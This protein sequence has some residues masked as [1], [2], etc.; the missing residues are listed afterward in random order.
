M[1]ELLFILLHI[2]VTNIILSNNVYDIS[3]VC[4]LLRSLKFGII[5]I[6]SFS[7]FFLLFIFYLICSCFVVVV[8]FGLVCLFL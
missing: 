2:S 1:C 8:L 3:I 5:F 6:W 7:F 4:L